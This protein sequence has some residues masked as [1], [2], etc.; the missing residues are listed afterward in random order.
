[1]DSNIRAR[2]DRPEV[3]DAV[4]R[5]RPAGDGFAKGPGEDDHESN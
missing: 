2:E 4:G 3:A 1:M 5:R